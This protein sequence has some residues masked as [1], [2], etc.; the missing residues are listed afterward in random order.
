MKRNGI[1][2]AAVVAALTTVTILGTA[3]PAG[4][5][6][7]LG[8]LAEAKG[9][10]FG[11]ELTAG[12]LGVSAETTIAAAQFDMVT[13]GNEMKWDTTEPSQ[14]RV[15]LRPGRPDRL[16]RPG[17]QHAGAR[18]QPGL[19][20]PAAGW[21]SQPAAQPGAGAMEEP[22][23]HRG[24]PLQ[25]PGVRLGRGQRAVQRGRHPPAGRVLPRHGRRLHRR[26]AAHRA[27]RRPGR[28][29]VPQ[30]LQHRGHRRQEQRDVQPGAVAA[31]AGRAARRH[32]ASRATSSSGQ[33]PVD[34]AGQHAAVRH[35]RPGRRGHR[36]GR[37]HPAAGQQRR[38]CSS[39]PPTSPPSSR[40]CLAVTR[41]VGVTQWAVGDA[42]SWIP[43]T[44]SGFG[45]ATMYDQSY[46]PK[47]AFT[48]T[49]VRPRRGA[50]RRDRHDHRPGPGGRRG[51]VPGRARP[52]DHR[53]HPAADLG[54]H[55]RHQ[56]DLDPHLAEPADRLRRHHACG[57]WTPSATGP[58]PAP[59]SRSGPA[60]AAPTSSGR[61]TPTGPSAACSPGCASTWS[62]RA[63]RTGP[64]SSSG[65]AAA[66]PTSAGRSVRGGR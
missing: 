12:D 61:S 57:A 64:W 59:R 52:V 16:L 35:P 40:D 19:A 24:H 50:R 10:Y 7:G 22:H 63:P 54:L 32:R 2:A 9:R 28:Q 36:A 11:T 56:P 21:V 39:R 42:D 48:A 14:R 33:V 23:H 60:T 1:G 5:A 31:G 15:Q 29:A 46:Q 55:R 20:Q 53:R 47:P 37:P 43:G 30:R 44:F 58:P 65:P 38:T 49:A 45:A 27:R 51:P 13:P 17:A 25:G 41:C 3:M 4:A 62:A 26:R 34:D 66:A 8:G 18:A 6:T